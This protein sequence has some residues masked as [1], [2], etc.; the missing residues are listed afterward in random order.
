MNYWELSF[1]VE[2]KQPWVEILIAELAEVGFESFTESDDGVQAYIQENDWNE[3]TFQ[4][5]ELINNPP[6]EVLISFAKSFIPVQNWNASWESSFEPVQLGDDLIIAAPF[7]QNLPQTRFKIIIEP[8]MSFGTGHHQTTKLMSK[9]LM[10]LQVLPS[11][12]L[13]MGCGT[14]VLAILAEKLGA[15]EILAID[16]EE[17][18]YEN[19][20]ENVERN[21]CTQIEV[22][23]GDARL[24]QNRHFNLI[25]ANINKNVLLSDMETYANC[26]NV[27]GILILSGF[28]DSDNE[29]LVGNAEKFN[30]ALLKAYSDENWSCLMFEKI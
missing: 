19:S 4:E 17:W 3:E 26:L 16:V 5:I 20:L 22:L 25:L 14:G 15:K 23:H 18:A 24:I 13:D 2:P 10:E 27:S 11:L 21:D 8:K 28:F 7:H 12:V 1:K 6:S 30:L 29:I 9:A